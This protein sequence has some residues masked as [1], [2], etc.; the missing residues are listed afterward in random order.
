MRVPGHRGSVVADHLGRAAVNVRV[1]EQLERV[2]LCRRRVRV[3]RCC[4]T[5]RLLLLLLLLVVVEWVTMLRMVM[6]LLVVVRMMLV[7]AVPVA[8]VGLRSGR[9]RQAMGLRGLRRPV[10][11]VVASRV[12]G[13]R[14]SPSAAVAVVMMPRLVRLHVQPKLGRR[15][16]ARR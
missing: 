5:V 13:M 11:L 2:P 1:H 16:S 8:T 6:L 15:S 7:L 3:I 10:V 14:E 9:G 4:V 12:R